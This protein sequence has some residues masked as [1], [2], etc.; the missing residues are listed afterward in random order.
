MHGAG[1]AWTREGDGPDLLLVHAGACDRRM[2]EPV[3]ALLRDRFRVLTYDLRGFGASSSY[4]PGPY[5][6]SADLL[7]VLDAVEVERCVVAGASFG[8]FVALEAALV[9]PARM[10][11][12]VLLDA[13]LPDHAWSAEVEAFGEA[14]EAALEDGDL[15]TAVALNVRTWLSG[16]ASAADG[17][18]VALMQ[19]RAFELQ[20]AAEPE[21]EPID[22]PAWTRLTEVAVATTV[23][24]G[25]DDLADFHAIADRLAAEIPGATR[26]TIEAAGH[27]PALEQ[28]EATAALI[29]RALG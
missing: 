7:G 4:E 9:A 15:D 1:L 25:S 26:E 14:E 22:P 13:P 20:L 29:A 24:T 2:W 6:P 11:A 10:A 27:L 28:P 23:A 3:S 19:R 8:A 21:P 16:H 5:A 12:L 18:L 17:A